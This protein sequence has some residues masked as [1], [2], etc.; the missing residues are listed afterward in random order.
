MEL[1]TKP[2]WLNNSDLL[3]SKKKTKKNKETQAEYVVTQGKNEEW[4]KPKDDKEVDNILGE[5]EGH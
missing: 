1:S 3:Y 2:E 4:L 5:E